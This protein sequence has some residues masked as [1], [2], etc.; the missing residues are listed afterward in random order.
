[1]LILLS[2]NFPSENRYTL[3]LKKWGIEKYHRGSDWVIIHSTTRKRS[4]EGK[5]SDVYI[6][7]RKYTRQ[8]VRREI[9]QHVL[10]G[11]EWCDSEDTLPDY[12]TVC[13]PREEV[14]GSHRDFLLRDLP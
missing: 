6:R 12:I 13:T 4:K 7:G 11:R 1:M 14:I 3:K 8:E 10:L 9:A 5:E 2:G